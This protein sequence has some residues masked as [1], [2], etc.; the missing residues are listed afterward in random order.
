MDRNRYLMN[1]YGMDINDFDI[2]D[3]LFFCA[4][5]FYI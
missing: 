5:L 4:I 3:Y 2:L 1:Y